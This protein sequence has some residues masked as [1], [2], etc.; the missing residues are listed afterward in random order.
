M[1][2]DVAFLPNVLGKK[3]T[4]PL[5]ALFRAGFVGAVNAAAP[6][7]VTNRQ[8]DMLRLSRRARG[9]RPAVLNA[10]HDRGCA[11]SRDS[12]SNFDPRHRF[13]RC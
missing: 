11:F 5:D 4:P 2:T 3:G 8:R 7:E 13:G 10:R 12:V 9:A 6:T 1:T